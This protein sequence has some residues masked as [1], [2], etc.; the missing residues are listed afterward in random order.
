MVI[1]HQQN[2]VCIWNL[3]LT[4]LPGQT[5]TVC[6]TWCCFI[7][8]RKKEYD[9]LWRKYFGICMYMSVDSRTNGLPGPF[10]HCYCLTSPSLTCGSTRGYVWSSAFCILKCVM[11]SS[12]FLFVEAPVNCSSDLQRCAGVTLLWAQ[13]PSPFSQAAPD[14]SKSFGA[15]LA[16]FIAGCLVFLGPNRFLKVLWKGFT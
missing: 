7:K 12:S 2:P 6:K 13:R 10:L 3:C 11:L 9:V 8:E 5:L 14:S 15:L 4:Q 16:L 1:Y